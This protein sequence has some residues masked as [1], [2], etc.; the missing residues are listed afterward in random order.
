[1]LPY[2]LSSLKEMQGEEASAAAI[3]ELSSSPRVVLLELILQASTV[4]SKGRLMR[5][6]VATRR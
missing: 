1:M 4:Y 6:M 5:V 3:A 2:V